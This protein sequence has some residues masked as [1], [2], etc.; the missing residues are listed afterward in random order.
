MKTKYLFIVINLILIAIYLHFIYWRF[1]RLEYLYIYHGKEFTIISLFTLL[2]HELIILLLAVLSLVGI[3]FRQDSKNFFI[4][5]T[6]YISTQLVTVFL[7]P[8]I[9]FLFF[10]KLF[11]VV[12]FL[13]LLIFRNVYSVYLNRRYLKGFYLFLGMFV[14]SLFLY[15]TW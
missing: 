7:A 2:Y 11:S 3:L 10:A 9:S 4:I 15:S 12:I 1:L 5:S 8:S 6:F 13:W 14:Y